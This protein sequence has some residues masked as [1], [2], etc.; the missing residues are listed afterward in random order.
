MLTWFRSETELLDFAEQLWP[1][2][3]DLNPKTMREEAMVKI[4]CHLIA[5]TQDSVRC[6][7]EERLL[8]L[9]ERKRQAQAMD[10]LEKYFKDPDPADGYEVCFEV[11]QILKGEKA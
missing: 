9:D 7:I 3:P 6:Y 5:K 10:K 4:F 11:F 1:K 8:E 2:R